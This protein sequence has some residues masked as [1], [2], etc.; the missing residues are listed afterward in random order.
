MVAVEA[1]DAV[2]LLDASFSNLATVSEDK[3]A[4]QQQL[5]DPK[6]INI[7]GAE[8]FDAFVSSK[9][10]KEQEELQESLNKIDKDPVTEVEKVEKKEEL[11]EIKEDIQKGLIPSLVVS[12]SFKQAG[13]SLPNTTAPKRYLSPKDFELLKCIGMGAFG[14]VLQVRNKKSKQIL[15]MKVISKRLLNRKSMAYVENMHAERNILIRVRHPFVVMMHAS[16]QTKFK[17]F[18]VMDFLAGG[19]L[20]LRLGRE[21]I[22]LEKTAAFYLSEI[23][24]A[25]EFLHSLGVLHRDLK[26]ENILLGEDGHVCLTDFGLAKDFSSTGGFVSEEDESRALTVCGT[27]E[28]MAPEMVARKGYGRPADYWSLGCI[29]FEMLT[30]QP[31]F[32]SKLGAKDLFRQIM[33]QKVK[34]PAGATAAACKLL[35]GLLNRTPQSRLGAARSTMFEVGGT[36]GLKQVA[37]FSHI[38]WDKLERKEV[39]PPERLDVTDEQD[40]KH[41]HDEFT[42]MPLPRSVIDESGDSFVARR[43]D[44]DNFRGFSFIQED[45]LLPERNA[46]ELENYWNSA[47]EEGE[48]ESDCASSKMGDEPEVP[49]EPEKKKRPPRKKKK[50]N[51]IAATGS[52]AMASEAPAQNSNTGAIA[53]DSN[54]QKDP[55]APEKQS[56]GMTKAS[57]NV[58]AA[59]PPTASRANDQPQEKATRQQQP[60]EHQ[61]KQP[62]SLDRSA[63]QKYIPPH[64]QNGGNS[65][66][67]VRNQ[68]QQAGLR[69]AGWA[70]PQQQHFQQQPPQKS[71]GWA[72]AN[73]HQHPSAKGGRGQ[74]RGAQG[75]RGVQQGGWGWGNQPTPTQSVQIRQQQQQPPSIK[76]TAAANVPQGPA[77]GSWAA[78]M[79]GGNAHCSAA[80]PR[81]QSYNN[82]VPP[83]PS[84][85]N[86]RL[87]AEVVPPSPSSDWRHHTMSPSLRTTKTPQVW[88]GLADFPAPPDLGK[89]KIA[90]KAVKPL[91]GAWGAK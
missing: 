16:F 60:I 3:P 26:P 80:A 63:S 70:G 18:I 85:K 78:K 71:G 19:E 42:K 55:S 27:Q 38:D 41:F 6:I 62:Y 24:L 43:V 77:P 64:H 30:G 49:L 25:L 1:V 11:A 73:Q 83:S 81:A 10:L 39:E 8:D 57:Q 46:E 31:P 79:A 17:L 72:V 50:K 51:L 12:D 15:A 68:H 69:Q 2:D 21:G 32:T 91:K 40:L 47:D 82:P 89:A 48:S 9:R 84:A 45:F 61:K 5:P 28:Y 37:F 34:M 87:I 58:E 44:S 36:A 66:V 56:A 67:P 13:D 20:F 88:P 74:G 65:S 23:I 53:V 14:K 76:N 22:F 35:K 90:P 59:A 33:S 86:S 54:L 4:L 75:G 52:A 7:D 29:A